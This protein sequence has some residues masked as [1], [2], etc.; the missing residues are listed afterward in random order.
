MD[1]KLYILVEDC[2]ERVRNRLVEDCKE[3]V[4]NRFV[5]GFIFGCLTAAFV[6][7][8]VV[9]TYGMSQL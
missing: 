3:R 1:E 2:K 9:Y 4:R 5:A 6:L 7:A 8:V